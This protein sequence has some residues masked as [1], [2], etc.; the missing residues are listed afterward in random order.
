MGSDYLQDAESTSW[1]MDIARDGWWE[2]VDSAD[3]AGDGRTREVLRASHDPCVLIFAADS[4]DAFCAMLI[5][6]AKTDLDGI[7][8]R[9]YQVYRTKP[10]GLSFDE[11][12]DSTP[13]S[14]SSRASARSRR[15]RD[16]GG[17]SGDRRS[18]DKKNSHLWLE[19]FFLT[20]ASS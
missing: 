11:A 14:L 3:P 13:Q 20:D 7:G 1:H 6:D 17:S 16:P 18:S 2:C 8:D 5:A 12:M 10:K 4:L 19:L 9:E 15:L